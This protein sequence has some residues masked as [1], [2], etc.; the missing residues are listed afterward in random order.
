MRSV[1]QVGVD[2]IK[3]YEG[4]SSTP[5]MCPANYVTVGYGH[6]VLP[7]ETHLFESGITMKQA[8]WLLRIDVKKAERAVLR[9]INVP[10]LDNQFDSLVSFTYN[11]GAGALQ[12]STLRRVINRGEHHDV[13]RQLNRWVYAGG[14][15]L[16]GLV[17][18]RVAEG[19]LYKHG[20]DVLTQKGS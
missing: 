15:K 13:A 18:R 2:I 1:T 5:Y 11:L 4:F 16:K 3:E 6:L 10:L 20:V 7:H 12:R 9:L 14:K 17:R 8:E 19:L